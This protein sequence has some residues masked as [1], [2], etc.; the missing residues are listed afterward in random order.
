MS[1][2]AGF[3]DEIVKSKQRPKEFQSDAFDKKDR[4]RALETYVYGPTV[5][6]AA[7][8]VF[9]SI[10]SSNENYNKDERIV[11]DDI[12]ISHLT[13]SGYIAR[14]PSTMFS[15]AVVIN[16]CL[17]AGVSIGSEQ[18]RENDI[19]INLANVSTK[20]FG[21]GKYQRVVFP[22]RR[23]ATP[24]L[25]SSEILIFRR[26]DPVTQVIRGA[27]ESVEAAA[28]DGNE[29]SLRIVEELMVTVTQQVLDHALS[30]EPTA[31]YNHIRDRAIEYIRDN[32][33]RPDL[34]IAE[35]TA[36]A[37]VSRATLY[38]AFENL[39]G[40][41]HFMTSERISHAKTMLR[42]GRNDRGHI[43]AVAYGSGFKSVEQFSKSF[44]AQT[45][46]TPTQ[47]LATM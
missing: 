1:V 40:L 45:S 4:L 9:S 30:T 21:P 15:D 28:I 16:T 36:Y 35:I 42:L 39:G 14:R 24:N 19:Y 2:L 25:T 31:G 29:K 27:T 17:S 46:L 47:F 34:S 8:P 13:T 18:V 26:D 6:H 43:T 11:S 5:Q 44:K 22:R 7:T 3:E 33:H 10:C 37:K 38:R 20:Q 12:L 32:L 23:L 41:K